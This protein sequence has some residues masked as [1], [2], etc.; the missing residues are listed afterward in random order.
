MFTD[1]LASFILLA[2][3]NTLI[4]TFAVSL[5]THIFAY[6]SSTALQISLK[7]CKLN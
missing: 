7:L 5:G 4:L 6:K 1:V 3:L 2:I